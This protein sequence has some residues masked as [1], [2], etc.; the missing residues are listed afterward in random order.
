VHGHTNEAIAHTLGLATGTVRIY[1]SAILV[2][3]GVPNRTAAAV[4]AIQEGLVDPAKDQ[5]A[6]R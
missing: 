4:F 5:I 6:I 1:V 3:L 2:K